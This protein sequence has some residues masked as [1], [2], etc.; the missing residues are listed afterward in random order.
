MMSAGEFYPL[1]DKKSPWMEESL[2]KLFLDIP[3]PQR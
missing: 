3:K 1:M 2:C